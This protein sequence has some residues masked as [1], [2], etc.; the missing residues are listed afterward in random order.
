MKNDSAVEYKNVYDLPVVDNICNQILREVISLAEISMA[1]VVMEPE[2]VSLLHK[3]SRISEIYFILEGRGILYHNN[4]ILE[5]EKGAYLALPPN[6]SH[7]LENVGNCNLEH[8]VLAIPPFNSSDVTLLNEEMPGRKNSQIAH[9]KF[10]S[11]RA[12]IKAQDGAIIYELLSKKE[13]QRMNVAL[14]VGS[15]PPK[16]KA[17][18]HFHKV[19]GEIYYIISGQGIIEVENSQYKAKKDRLIYIPANSVHALENTS[20]F[21]SLDVLCVSAPAY[22]DEDF[23][24]K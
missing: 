23:Y 7:K 24:K 16:R 11:R 22:S 5:V 1:H 18:P 17:I 15:L 12:P 10:E 20:K 8:L 2:N 9:V 3:H 19:S 14:A 4:K 13:K 21:K 6:T